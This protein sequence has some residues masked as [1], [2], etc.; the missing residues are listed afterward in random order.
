MKIYI[1]FRRRGKCTEKSFDTL[2][3][4]INYIRKWIGEIKD[5]QIVS[6]Y[7]SNAD[8]IRIEIENHSGVRISTP[9]GEAIKITEVL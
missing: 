1:Y 6:K 3:K 2:K 9:L 8:L 4:A 5:F 7:C